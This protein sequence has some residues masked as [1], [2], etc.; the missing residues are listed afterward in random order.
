[1][2]KKVIAIFM[3]IT[4]LVGCQVLAGCGAKNA[5]E[6]GLPGLDSIT[7]NVGDKSSMIEE[8]D[9]AESDKENQEST[10]ADGKVDESQEQEVY[11]LTF[12]ATT[13]EGEALTSECFANAKLTMINVWATYCNPCLSEMPDLGEIA[14][15]YDPADF[16]MIGIIS[17]VMEDGA[18]SD[19]DY[20][21][22]LIEE[23][24]ATTYP[25]LLLNESLYMNLVG[26]VSGVPTTFF[27]N[28]KGELL[29]YLVG[30]QAKVTWTSLIDD[31]LAE[32]KEE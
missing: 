16:Q 15:E 29:G 3:I 26:A 11:V 27:V 32:M 17:D 6:D 14:A 21:K 10:N 25:H 8:Q 28:E 18:Q 23:T 13:T 2:K 12:E 31:L 22:Q 1:M 20:A 19:I 9:K 7:E 5:K 24:S 30:A 4:M